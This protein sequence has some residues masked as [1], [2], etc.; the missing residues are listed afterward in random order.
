MATPFIFDLIDVLR[1]DP[2]KGPAIR[3]AAAVVAML[4][5]QQARG[6]AISSQITKAQADL[7]TTCGMN[8][9]LLAP[10]MIPKFGRRGTPM[11]LLNRP[12][13]FAMTCLAPNTTVTLR[14]GR[15]VGKCADGDTVVSTNTGDTT[16][17]QLFDRAIP[18]PGT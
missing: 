9:G 18:V 7:I 11:S 6:K 8:F 16:L 12:F 5:D 4:E 1:N 14:A 17:R 2:V 3:K 13:M 10:Y 15:R